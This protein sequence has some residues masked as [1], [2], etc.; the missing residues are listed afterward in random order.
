[1]AS[2][3]PRVVPINGWPTSR[4]NWFY[5]FTGGYRVFI[6]FSLVLRWRLRD[7]P[8]FVGFQWRCTVFWWHRACLHD[9]AAFT[10]STGSD[11]TAPVDPP[12]LHS[13]FFFASFFL[14]AL[15]L[16]VLAPNQNSFS[17]VPWFYQYRVIFVVAVWSAQRVHCRRCHCSSV[18]DQILLSVPIINGVLLLWR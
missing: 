6:G 8:G 13:S 9:V 1:M 15:P 16:S 7:L 4:I 10:E 14:F 12:T 2:W 11:W 18:S 17:L 5:R 3:P